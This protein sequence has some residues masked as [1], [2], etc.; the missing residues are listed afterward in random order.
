MWHGWSDNIIMPQGTIDY[1]NAVVRT[2]DGGNVSETQDWM[3]L[4]MVPG[5]THCGMDAGVFFDALVEWVEHGVAPATVL[6]AVSSKTTRP[7]CPHPAVAVYN[8]SGSTD[9]AANFGCAASPV[10]DTE[11]CNTRVNMRL[12]KKPFVPSKPCP[13][14]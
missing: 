7:L 13:G 10:V 8:G 1:Y 11:D 12:F 2:V 14:C 6:H 3:R 5:V 4:F 9:D